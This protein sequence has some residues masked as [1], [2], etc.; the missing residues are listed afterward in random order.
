MK[1]EKKG[2]EFLERPQVHEV[3]VKEKG[4]AGGGGGE[5]GG[6][7]GGGE[8]DGDNRLVESIELLAAKRDG[9]A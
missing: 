1:C 8:E 9:K 3:G 5:G 6:G 7:G 2:C 4:G